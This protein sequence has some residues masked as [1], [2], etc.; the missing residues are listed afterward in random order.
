MHAPKSAEY[1]RSEYVSIRW[2]LIN[3]DDGAYM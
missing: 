2:L 3:R 1:G